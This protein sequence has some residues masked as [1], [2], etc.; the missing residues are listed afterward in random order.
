[1]PGFQRRGNGVVSLGW[2]PQSRDMNVPAPLIALLGL[3]AVV[4]LV[5]YG[6]GRIG[7]AAGVS[8]VNVCII[9][10]SVYLATAGED[11]RLGRVLGLQG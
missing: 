5:L 6:V 2:G 3:L 1:M 9:V 7:L 4:P 8:I 10:A 11:S